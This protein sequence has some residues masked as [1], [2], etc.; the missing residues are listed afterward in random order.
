MIPRAKIPRSLLFLSLVLAI[1]ACSS[2]YYG[3]MESMGYEKRDILVERIQEGKESQE[4]AKK[5]FQSALEQFK[6]LTNYSGGA[7]EKQYEDLKTQ[8]ERSKARA[9]SVHSR[10]R[11]IEKVAKDLFAEWDS[12]I[13]K[14]NDPKLQEDSKR[15]RMETEDRYNKMHAAMAKA[16]TSMQPVVDKFEGHVLYLKHQLNAQAIASLQGKLQEIE[17]DVGDLIRDME[18]SIAEADEF[19]NG[20][21]KPS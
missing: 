1:P 3:V 11:S 17:T 7:L 16:E 21:K 12:E 5:Q 14:I 8:L 15:L 20:I 4:E 18:K 10:V 9:E 2:V 13:P 6:A 19:M